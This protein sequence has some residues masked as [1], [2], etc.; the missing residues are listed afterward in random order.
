MFHQICGDKA[1]ARVVI[2]TTNW[3][4]V[5][6]EIGKD[7]EQHFATNLWKTM[8]NSGSKLLRFDQTKE[9]AR[10]FLD[11]ILGQLEIDKNGEIKNDIT[12]RIQ[13][14]LVNLDRS[15][16]E[17]A[18]GQEL[19]YMLQQL[20][21]FETHKGN[22]NFENAAAL[23]ASIEKQIDELH[24]PFR[25]KLILK[26]FVSCFRDSL[27]LW[28][29]LPWAGVKFS[30]SSWCAKFVLLLLRYDVILKHAHVPL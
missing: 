20:L 1:L 28:L 18:A 29:I 11:A 5:N 9:S 8:I 7:R 6:K 14:E 2:G 17:T 19:R 3:E 22:G 23:S 15:I 26:F 10:A 16:A 4:E 27:D 13:N 24:I 30:V 25:R 21:V 12:L